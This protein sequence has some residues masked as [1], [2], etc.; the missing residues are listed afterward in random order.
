M[1]GLILPA[2]LKSKMEQRG[3]KLNRQ[4]TDSLRQETNSLRE[5]TKPKGVSPGGWVDRLASR[6]NA[7]VLCR[8]HQSK[9]D[10]RKHHYYKDRKFPYVQGKCD[11]CG[12]LDVMAALYIHESFLANSDGETSRGQCWTPK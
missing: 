9:F 5:P 2:Y 8:L 4:K 12:E 7:L 11:A 3:H 10:H 1:S 6:H